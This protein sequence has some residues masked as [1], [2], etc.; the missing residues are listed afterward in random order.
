MQLRSSN[1]VTIQYPFTINIYMEYCSNCITVTYVYPYKEVI[2]KN[3]SITK[4]VFQDIN[5]IIQGLISS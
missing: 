4:L 3:Y 5:N 1:I 2:Y